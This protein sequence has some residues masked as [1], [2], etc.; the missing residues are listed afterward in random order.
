M[1]EAIVNAIVELHKQ[2]RPADQERVI[3]QSLRCVVSDLTLISLAQELGID[4]DKV[5]ND[6]YAKA[7]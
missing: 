6:F 3:R 2:Q 4:T 1:R 5:I 7:V